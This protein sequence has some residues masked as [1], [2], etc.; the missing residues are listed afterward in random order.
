MSQSF[1]INKITNSNTNLQIESPTFLDNVPSK[2]SNMASVEISLKKEI[3][4][5]KEKRIRVSQSNIF[6]KNFRFNKISQHTFRTTA[7]K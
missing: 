3:F 6:I 5:L 7:H 1:N 4:T 2:M